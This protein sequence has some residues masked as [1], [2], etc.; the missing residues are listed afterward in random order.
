MSRNISVKILLQ[1]KSASVAERF[2]TMPEVMDPSKK[3]NYILYKG[4][5]NENKCMCSMTIGLSINVSFITASLKII[6]K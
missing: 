3:F 5:I 6:K 1:L 4:F 2:R